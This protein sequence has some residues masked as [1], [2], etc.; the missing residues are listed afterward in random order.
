MK[1]LFIHQ[2]FPG[3]YK[4]LAQSLAAAGHDCV[5]LTLRV[6]E[7][8]IWNGVQIIPYHLMQRSDQSTHPWVLDFDTKVT[9][10]HACFAAARKLKERGFEPDLIL[11]HPGWGEAMFLKDVWPDARMGLYCELYHLSGRPH[12]GFDPE[13]EAADTLEAALRIRMKN[14]HNHLHFE[15]ADA[16]IS[17]TAFQA[18]TFP[19]PFRNKITVC[20]DGIDTETSRPDPEVTLNLQKRGA[21]SRNDEIITFVNRNL[22]PYR[23]YHIFMRALPRLLRERPNATVLVVGGNDVSYGG[24]PPEGQTWKQIFIDEV[25]QEISDSD[26]ERVRFLDRIPHAQFTKLL[27]I[28]TVHIYLTYPFVLSWS[29]LEAM[30]CGAAIVASATAPVQ[31]VIRDG[32]TGQLVDFFDVDGL[33]ERVSALLDDPDR[34]LAFG[35]AARAEMIAKYDLKSICLP[36]QIAWVED[37]MQ[38]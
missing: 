11:A 1:I 18:D 6:K 7:A 28:S 15:V 33:V 29:L 24:R 37:V 16:G 9:R 38:A 25:R 3:Q 2:N 27:Q 22:E 19:N 17:P 10:A 20:H 23:G 32:E 8:K 12:G 31:E 4:H 36:R 35:E 13:F 30:S 14:L 5:A 26:W 21:L 34:R